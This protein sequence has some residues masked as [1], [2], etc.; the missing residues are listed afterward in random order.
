M[1]VPLGQAEGLGLGLLLSVSVSQA[2]EAFGVNWRMDVVEAGLV[3]AR[4]ETC[5]FSLPAGL[6]F[7]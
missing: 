6:P 2:P 3:L 1:S 7:P 4:A 5:V